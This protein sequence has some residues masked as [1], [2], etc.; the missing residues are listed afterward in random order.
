MQQV[1]QQAAFHEMT[2]W[3]NFIYGFD[4]NAKRAIKIINHKPCPLHS[5]TYSLNTCN[6]ET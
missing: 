5:I 6:T 1:G 3:L 4:D 2:H